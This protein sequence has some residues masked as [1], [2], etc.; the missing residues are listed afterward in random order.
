MI[1]FLRHF[2]ETV[3]AVPDRSA[4]VDRDGTRTTTYQELYTTACKVNGWLRAHGIGREDVCAIYL[5]K[6]MELLAARLG[7][8]MAGCAWVVLEDFMGKER[9]EYV[10]RDSGC[11]AV[12][13]EEAWDEAMLLALCGEM[14]DS[15]DHDLAFLIYTS[16]STGAPKGAAQEYGVYELISETILSI[17]GAYYKPEPMNWAD[18]VPP[19]FIVSVHIVVGMLDVRGTIH[20]ISAEMVTDVEALSEYFIEKEIHHT[21]M[22]PTY[23]KLLLQNPGIQLRAAVTGGE[24]ASGIYTDRFDLMNGYS[25]SEIGFFPFRFKLDRAYDNTPVGYP[26]PQSE[27]LLLDEDGQPSDE[28][29]FYIR[30]PY[31]RGYLGGDRSNFIT[32][33]GKE[34]FR[35]SDYAKRDPDGKYT[36]LDR[37]DDIV[38]LNGNRVDT[39]EVEAAVKRVLG[40]DFCCVRLHRSNGIKALCAYY[41][42][43]R[44]LESIASAQALRGFIPEYMIPSFYIR[45]S[46]IP[47]NSHGKLDK[48]ALPEPQGP[49]RVSLY[50]APENRRQRRLC[51]TIK[52]VLELKDDVGMDDDFFMLGGDS[53]RAMEVMVDC[54][55]PGLSVQMIYEGRTV[56]RI[57]AMLPTTESANAHTPKTAR[58]TPSAVPVNAGQRY[59]L[60]TNSHYPGTCML[61]LPVR[62]DLTPEADL[63]RLA[64]AVRVVV[65]T[66]P[67]LRSTIEERDGTWFLRYRPE[68]DTAFPVKEMTDEALEQA[69]AAFVRPFDLDGGPLFR[70]RLIRGERKNV[71]LL[72]VFHAICDGESLAKLVDDIGAVFVGETLPAADWCY[73]ILLEEAE[74]YSSQ[75]FQRDLEYFASLYDHP[76]WQTLP[77]PDHDSGGNTDGRLFLPFDFLPQDMDSLGKQ[78][79]LGK[80]GVYF[81]AAALSIAAYNDAE[82]IMITW[83]WHGRSDRRRMESVGY[84]IQDLP[85]AVR[86]KGGLSLSRLFED[87]SRQISE[88]ISHGSLSYWD[89]RDTYE[90]LTCCLYQGDLHEYHDGG[91]LVTGVRELPLPSVAS[92]NTLDVQI[93]DGQDAFG[94]LLDYNASVYEQRSMERFG[95]IFRRI[96]ARFLRQNPNTATVGDVLRDALTDLAI[97]SPM[98]C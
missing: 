21:F 77:K 83:I 92:N 59:L 51:E 44:E 82:N 71:V 5:P 73:P 29:V 32:I 6:G 9:I 43:D 26:A 38:K 87:V 35:N 94:V 19:T 58:E 97:E 89:E 50:A 79:G 47:L 42:A 17:I 12:L 98:P 14:A 23:M 54:E 66:H 67:A 36:V 4:V 56:R 24:I 74:R 72:D 49:L 27:I 53:I 33:E 1:P 31:F 65:R 78:F 40:V 69:A 76:G 28:G 85:I 63:E 10:I 86:L 25:S 45:L 96:C 62:F 70:C 84:F 90:H 22:T 95:R 52:R 68:T 75:R 16:G 46:E 18:V 2:C 8:M 91:S 3:K 80:G 41:M 7:V 15:D 34:Y 55:I 61:N 37:V 57:G 13:N 64:E 30:L 48:R 88:G 81:T 11:K 93:L 39:R 20:A 60:E